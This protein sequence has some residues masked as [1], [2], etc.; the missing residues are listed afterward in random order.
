MKFAQPPQ[1]SSHKVNW[2]AV[3]ADIHKVRA[4]FTFQVC[5]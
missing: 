1:A 5:P 4:N 2:Q 3:S